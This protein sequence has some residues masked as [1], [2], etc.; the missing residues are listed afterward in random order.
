MRKIKNDMGERTGDRQKKKKKTRGLLKK[1][2]KEKNKTVFS[3]SSLF[4]HLEGQ[5]KDVL[6]TEVASFQ[7]HVCVW[8]NKV[9]DKF[10]GK[11][12]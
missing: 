3:F 9:S 12:I 8:L 5:N 1:E 6:E 2:G 4:C 7:H 10:E 11:S